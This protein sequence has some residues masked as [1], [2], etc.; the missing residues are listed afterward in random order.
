MSSIL[1]HH[2]PEPLYF[3]FARIQTYRQESRPAGVRRF[4]LATC[5]NDRFPGRCN[6]AKE[7]NVR[8]M[9]RHMHSAESQIADALRCPPETR[10]KSQRESNCSGTSQHDGW[11]RHR[12]TGADELFTPG[13]KTVMMPAALRVLINR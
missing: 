8:R 7:R 13:S 4:I 9:L 5:C 1:E 12:P 11:I 2:R 10:G 3:L 6:R